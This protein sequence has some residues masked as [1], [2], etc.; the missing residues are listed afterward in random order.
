MVIKQ[1][2]VKKYFSDVKNGCNNLIDCQNLYKFIEAKEDMF[3][4]DIRKKEDFA[5][6]HIEG[7]IHCDWS[8]VFDFIEEDILPID[9]KIVVICY[10]GQTAGQVVGVLKTLGYDACSLMGGM[11]NGWMKNSM[12]IKATC[13]T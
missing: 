10:S 3:L 4:L 13:S 5:K 7:S 9:K 2:T 11:N 12:P 1:D 6:N 8:E